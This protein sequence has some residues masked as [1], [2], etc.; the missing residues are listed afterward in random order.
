MKMTNA[1]AEPIIPDRLGISGELVARIAVPKGELHLVGGRGVEEVATW[2]PSAI[3]RNPFRLDEAEVIY[4]A[5]P[6]GFINL[7]LHFILDRIFNINTP[8]TAI[9]HM[10]ISNDTTA[11]TA[12][13]L[14]ID[15]TAGAGSPDFTALG[16]G[17]GA[18]ATSRTGNTVTCS[19]GWEPADFTTVFAI[20]KVGLSTASTDAGDDTVPTVNGVV[21]IIGGT[22]G[23]APYNEPFSID[24][25]TVSDFD[26]TLQIQVTAQ[27]T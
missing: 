11:V 12:T 6:N 25:T 4:L 17:V 23:A 16:S 7:G 27:A 15:P 8:A 2:K 22:G 3:P 24:L 21:N 9:T 1:W 18:A 13:T 14:L 26:L 20:T 5:R 10:G 19:A